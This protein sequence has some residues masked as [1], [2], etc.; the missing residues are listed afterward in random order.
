[1]ANPVRSFPDLTPAPRVPALRLADAPTGALL[2]GT[3]HVSVARDPAT[4]S[5]TIT[6]TLPDVSG[7]RFGCRLLWEGESRPVVV[8]ED[9]PTPAELL[10]SSELRAMPQ[11]WPAAARSVEKSWQP[12]VPSLARETADDDT[13]T[14]F[15]TVRVNVA[16]RQ[17]LRDEVPVSLSP[18]AFDL[19]LALVRR[20][21]AIVSRQELMTSVWGRGRRRLTARTVDTHICELRQKLE[22]DPAHP[23]HI[24]TVVKSGYRLQ[25]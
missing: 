25:R 3:G 16:A 8:I 5:V 13:V 17:V 7:V 18:K 22:V 21:G 24:L 11:G 23:R 4:A 6:F 15:G 10:A 12:I 20:G 9:P 19:F 14:C 2:A 1:M